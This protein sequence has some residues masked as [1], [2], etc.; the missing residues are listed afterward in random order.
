[1]KHLAINDRLPNLDTQLSAWPHYEEDEVAAAM[2]VLKS[3]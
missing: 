2:H 1:M 3:G